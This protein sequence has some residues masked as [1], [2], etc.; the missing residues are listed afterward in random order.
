MVRKW[1]IFKTSFEIIEPKNSAKKQWKNMD[2]L[3]KMCSWLTTW[4][5]VDSIHPWYVLSFCTSLNHYITWIVSHSICFKSNNI[6][7]CID[8]YGRYQAFSIYPWYV[9]IICTS[10]ITE[11][12]LI[13][14]PK[15]C[16]W[17][18]TWASVF[19][20]DIY[21]IFEHLHQSE[22]WKNMDCLS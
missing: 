6:D 8:I 9:L 13:I 11:R 5:S 22:E 15:M 1:K 20:I 19:S 12:V 3:S 18:T 17:F 21:S 7:L 16:F 4:A 2:C 14:C 10:L